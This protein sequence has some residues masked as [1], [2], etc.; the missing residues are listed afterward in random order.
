MTRPNDPYTAEELALAYEL[1]QEGCS[2]K[3]IMRGLG[4][5]RPSV[6]NNAVLRAVRFG[7]RYRPAVCLASRLQGREDR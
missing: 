3:N 1:R 4:G 6:I 7:L 2:W 5:R